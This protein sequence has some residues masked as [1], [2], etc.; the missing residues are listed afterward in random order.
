MARSARVVAP[1]LPHHITQRG[2]SGQRVFFDDEDRMRYVSLITDYCVRH[3]LSILSFCLMHNH[4]HFIAVPENPF[5]LARVFSCAHMRYS[6]Y[7]NRKRGKSGHL[8]W[9][10][11][12]SCILDERHL[13]QAARYI[14]RNPVRALMVKAPWDWRWSSAL[15]HIGE[16]KSDFDSMNLLSLIGMTPPQWKRY[17]DSPEKDDFLQDIRKKTLTGRPLVSSDI[18]SHLEIK[19]DR[20]LSESIVGRPKGSKKAGLKGKKIS[21]NK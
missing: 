17:V 5:T 2:N 20:T 16:S 3:S 9:A 21:G 13:I 8:W 4:V 12:Y 18:L 6:Q 7:L 14:E 15:E 11:F 10:R 1:G 19:F